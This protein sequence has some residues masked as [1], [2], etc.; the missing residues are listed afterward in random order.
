LTEDTMPLLF[1]L[2]NGSPLWPAL[3]LVRDLPSDFSRHGPRESGIP[4]LLNV[5][6]YPPILHQNL[7]VFF[8]FRKAGRFI[9]LF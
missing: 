3:S 1:I 4:F 6:H 5:D 2:V 8:S 9:T 7:R